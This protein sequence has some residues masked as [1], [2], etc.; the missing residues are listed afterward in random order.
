VA[1]NCNSVEI[2]CNCCELKLYHQPYSIIS[3]A[4]LSGPKQ[5]GW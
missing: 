1:Q 3:A 2:A 4:D 5:R